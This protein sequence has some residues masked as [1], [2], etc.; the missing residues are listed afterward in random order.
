[1]NRPLDNFDL[2][3][4]ANA[5]TLI[6]STSN[7][8]SYSDGYYTS[9]LKGNFI[10]TP[11]SLLGT[12]TGASYSAGGE[13]Y[14]T[15][16]GLNISMQR[17]KTDGFYDGN[18][19]YNGSVGNDH[20]YAQLGDDVYNGGE[21]RDTVHYTADRSFFTV[22]GNANNFT[23]KG[24]GKTDTLNSIER[25]AFDNGT[26][27]LD[28]KAGEA[29]GSAYRAY[30]AAF[31]RKPDTAGLKYWVDKMDAGTSLTEVALGFVQSAEFQKLHTAPDTNSMIT[32][33]YQNVLHRAPD[34]TGLAYWSNAAATGTQTHEMLAAFSES[35]ENVNNTAA[36][37]KNG[38][39]LEV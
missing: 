37:M 34:A 13:D 3:R 7:Q 12:I 29:A 10:Y 25:V 16:S 31:D 21:G 20:F 38:I 1:Y 9:T 11:S 30:Q 18:D 4:A 32:S 28:V 33:F 36:A 17:L 35:T 14:V 27:A 6:S 23:V 39:W 22:T 5:G 24:L 19:T 15:I 8:I 26:L 2:D